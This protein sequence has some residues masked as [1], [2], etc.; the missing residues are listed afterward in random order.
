MLPKLG[1]IWQDSPNVAIFC[2][3]WSMVVGNRAAAGVW[4]TARY[5]AVKASSRTC[6]SG[7]CLASRRQGRS[8]PV[9]S[10]M[11]GRC[12]RMTQ[13]RY[14]R[15]GEAATRRAVHATGER[16]RCAGHNGLPAGLGSR[17]SRRV[18]RE[19]SHGVSGYG[20]F[21]WSPRAPRAGTWPTRGW[22][23]CSGKAPLAARPAAQHGRGIGGPRPTTMTD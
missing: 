21:N 13:G 7:T 1:K 4:P 8:K 2:H 14:P 15:A 22:P 23:R 11:N 18:L 6:R 5:P 10:V 19:G 17:R 16:R 12:R 3:Y 20:F 9:K